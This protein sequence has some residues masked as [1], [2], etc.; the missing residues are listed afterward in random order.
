[1]PLTSLL[2]M[3]V[4]GGILL[5]KRYARLGWTFILVSLGGL[6]TLS[7]PITAQRLIHT[8]EVYAPASPTDLEQAQALVVLGGGIE[9]NQPEYAA[10]VLNGYTLERIRYA[11]F[12]YQRHDLPILVTGGSPLGGEA[13]GWVMKRELETLFSVPVRWLE[14]GSNNTAQNAEF[15]RRILQ[16]AGVDR[17][18]LVT[19]AWHMPRAKAAF[20][21]AGFTVVPAPTS[22]QTTAMPGVMKFVPQAHYLDMSNIAL[23]EWLGLWWYALLH[24]QA[25]GMR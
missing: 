21:R 17:I 16:Q 14:T 5:H 11:A 9:Q 22:F 12:L 6:T 23:R 13:E 3:S 19:H 20:E 25:A 18:A 7:M 4:V 24:E 15:S 8:L 10:D 2:L 1:M